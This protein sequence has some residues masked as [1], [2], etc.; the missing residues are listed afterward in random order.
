LIAD[1]W[2]MM[3]IETTYEL[4]EFIGDVAT[5]DRLLA[6]MAVATFQKQFDLYPKSSD[7]LTPFVFPV[8]FRDRLTKSGVT[9]RRDE[10]G[11][12]VASGPLVDLLSQI[13]SLKER[14]KQRSG[15]AR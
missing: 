3:Q 8:T 11:R 5:A 13:E 12:L 10:R 6:E 9:F 2:A 15:Q 1:H 4:D 7:D 14:F